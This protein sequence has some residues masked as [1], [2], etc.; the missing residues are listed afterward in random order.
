MTRICRGLRD[1]A[2]LEGQRGHQRPPRV[3]PEQRQKHTSGPCSSFE[4]CH[5]PNRAFSPHAAAGSMRL[6]RSW[7]TAYEGD[8]ELGQRLPPTSARSLRLSQQTMPRLGIGRMVSPPD[9]CLEIQQRVNGHRDP[10]RIVPLVSLVPF[11]TIAYSLV[12]WKYYQQVPALHCTH[13]ELIE[14]ASHTR[15][16]TLYIAALC[17]AGPFRQ[18]AALTRRPHIPTS[19]SRRAADW[20]ISC[21]SIGS[22]S[23]DF[24]DGS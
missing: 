5:H 20:F 18:L 9:G 13:Q 15:S 19:S 14:K 22:T 1:R 8:N 11:L 12:R 6:R 10:H 4:M 21:I 3:H 2:G 23:T 16:T 24:T 7:N 17:R